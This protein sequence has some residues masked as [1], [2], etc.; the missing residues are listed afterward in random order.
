MAWRR[1]GDKP[2]SKPM[3]GSLPTHICVTRPQWT[4]LLVRMSRM[5]IHMTNTKVITAWKPI[6]FLNLILAYV[7]TQCYGLYYI[8]NTN[9]RYS[10]WFTHKAILRCIKYLTYNYMLHEDIGTEIKYLPI[11]FYVKVL[12]L[13]FCIKLL[14]FWLKIY[15]NVCQMPN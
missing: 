4:I 12:K 14:Y 11:S 10:A 7:Y 13:F 6:N 3:M 5:A 15:W 1:P 9:Q 8:Y 2:L